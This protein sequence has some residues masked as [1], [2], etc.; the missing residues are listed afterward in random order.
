MK[1]LEKIKSN[2]NEYLNEVSAISIHFETLS[3][4]DKELSSLWRDQIKVISDS[5]A[6]PLFRIAV[7]GTV[8]SG[9]STFINSI[10][11]AELLKRGAGIITAFVTRIVD[12]EKIQG[13]IELK[14]WEQING[15]I[16]ECLRDLP[17]VMINRIGKNFLENCDLR[18]SENR[19]LLEACIAELKEN[20]MTSTGI[21]DSNF[22]ILNA[23]L[24]GYPSI[25]PLVEDEP[26]KIIFDQ[27]HILDHQNFVGE[28]SQAVYLK[29]MEIQYPL[30]PIGE[31][32]E[33]ADCQGI[34][35]P[36]PLHFSLVQDYLLKSHFIIYVIN[37]R[38]GLREADFKLL[39]A[40]DKLKLLGNTLFVL[41]VDLDSHGDLENW[42]ESV[43][44]VKQ[45]LSFLTSHGDIY[46]F[47]CLLQLLESNKDNLDKR[48][49]KRLELWESD[50]NFLEKSKR[51]F[52]CFI[53]QLKNMVTYSRLELLVQSVKFR[54]LMI[55]NTLLQ[56]IKNRMILFGKTEERLDDISERI[57]EHSKIMARQLDSVENLIEG[58]RESFR[59]ELGNQVDHFFMGSE[60]SIIEKTLESIEN[61]S[62]DSQFIQSAMTNQKELL[63]NIYSFYHNFRHKVSKFLVEEIK[64]DILEFAKK[65][66]VL[67]SSEVERHGKAFWDLFVSKL[68]V[69]QRE[70]KEVGINEPLDMPAF[71]IDFSIEKNELP[72]FNLLTKNHP[73]GRGSFMLKFGFGQVAQAFNLL[74]R[75][76]L[77]KREKDETFFKE[78]LREA[79]LFLKKETKKELLFS[80]QDFHQNF[81]YVYVFSYADSCLEKLRLALK[82]SLK[83]VLLDLSSLAEAIRKTDF[84]NMKTYQDLEELEKVVIGLRDTIANLAVE[85]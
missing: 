21:I 7:V 39:K 55:I 26:K 22:L 14:S 15:E 32:I 48:E 85:P 58:L 6:S 9:K 8:K 3:K 27:G 40:I 70:L 74:K 5:M 13:W 42:K 2:I 28:E 75:K 54:L 69:L 25:S 59:K 10:L 84:Q 37:S 83:M 80:L 68:N 60:G 51:N 1:N 17:L 56:S 43:E 30:S 71:A 47:S 29:D 76:L 67:I 64:V 34:D 73:I 72:P 49:K 4:V 41:N 11:Q 77:G 18:L 66:N 36:N 45:E 35:S 31:A 46:D 44:R 57:E 16:R 65:S 38:I 50:R 23:Y 62:V 81:K 53:A 24:K 82:N 52:E 19:E 78:S 12:G 61:Y 20:G 63:V 33:I 79:I